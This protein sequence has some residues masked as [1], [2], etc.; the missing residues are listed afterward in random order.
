MDQEP[1]EYGRRAGSYILFEGQVRHQ[2]E[3]VKKGGEY[4]KLTL[5][6]AAAL[7]ETKE[8]M[9][10]CAVHMHMCTL[11]RHTHVCNCAGQNAQE[12]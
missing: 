12:A 10:V 8:A 9:R 6:Y 7:K 4:L 2:T 5:F 3:K 1:V 11:H